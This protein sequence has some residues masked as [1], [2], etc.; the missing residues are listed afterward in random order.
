MNLS[1][2]AARGLAGAFLL[3]SGSSTAFAHQFG[4]LQ[5]DLGAPADGR[6]QVTVTVDP[7]H[8]P[9]GLVPESTPAGDRGRV[10]LDTLAAALVFESGG[11]KLSMKDGERSAP[12]ATASPSGGLFLYRSFFLDVP[13][14]AQ[15]LRIGETLPVGAFV[16]RAPA[17]EGKDAPLHWAEG[18]GAAVEVVLGAPVA[19]PSRGQVFRQ[20]VVLGFTHILP[21]GL[22]HICFVLGLFLLSTRWKALLVQVTS[23]TVAHTL[24]LAASIYGVV[25]PDHRI[26][27]GS[28]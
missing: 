19:A 23:F 13:E 5:V 3:F 16:V 10:A 28:Q 27:E 20:Y 12:V 7:E 17:I 15:E 4:A 26:Y 14:G 2:A 24:T 6:V 8:L 11:E 22:D 9:P 1:Q 25:A 18:G 21:K